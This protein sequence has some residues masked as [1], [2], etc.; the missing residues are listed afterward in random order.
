MAKQKSL[1]KSTGLV[2][3][4]T[5]T[6]RILGFVR[7]MVVAHIFGAGIATDAFFVAFKIP[8]FMRR[9]F[10][11]GAFSQAF[12][13]VLS[14]YREQQTH[15]EARDFLRHIAGTLGL[16]LLLVTILAEIITPGLIALFAPGF[17]KDPTRFAMAT[18]M[19]R[20]TF[21]YLLFISLT[22]FAGA[23]L[24]S[25]GNFGIP[26]FT[27]VLLN[28][29]MI[30]AA[31]YGAPHMANPIEALAWGVCVAGIIQFLF[32]LPFLWR[33]NLLV[34]P[35]VN[36][37]DPG[38]RRVL[39]LMVPALFGVSVAQVSLLIDTVFASFLPAGS[40]SWL[41]FSDRLSSFP[42]GVFG[43]AIATVIL[44]SLS[45]KHANKSPD[46]YASTLDWA[47]RCVLLIGL[48]SALGLL[49]LSG[50]LLVSLFQYGEF[51]RHDVLMA[52]R[53]LMA[54]AVGVPGFMFIKVL[55]SGFYA[56]QNV[57]TPVKFAVVAMLTNMVLNLALVFPLAHAGL[58]LATAISSSLNAL[59]LFYGLKK[60]G[61]YTPQSG[62]LKY[63][64]RLALANAAMAV[65]LWWGSDNVDQWLA[66]DWH[67]RALH[68]SMLV[69]CGVFIYFFC[70]HLT[71]L[72]VKDFRHPA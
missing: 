45:R 28:L 41:Y 31:L 54:F 18:D 20:V 66:W 49:I 39:T 5:M 29:A 2:S 37:S 22:A 58:A 32:Q 53:S 62:W 55:A 72:K 63:A 25:Y 52:Q 17:L 40:V 27:P 21:P 42:L 44:P 69:F 61:I 10:A 12:V 67:T 34:W 9:L 8:N 56:Q 48:P 38:V 13:P 71:G 47:I 23:T 24:N 3:S 65:A 33:L 11:E 51:T 30:V 7:D 35:K 64:G 19:L 68:L 15:A 70:L 26:A 60:R 46:A 50:P 57:K 4:M 14:G 43:V 1:A 6:S 16:A 36:W 59:L